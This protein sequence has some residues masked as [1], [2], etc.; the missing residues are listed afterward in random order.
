MAGCRRC[1][2]Q[3]RYSHDQH[4]DPTARHE[5]GGDGRGEGVDGDRSTG[6]GTRDAHEHHKPVGHAQQFIAGIPPCGASYG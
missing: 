4:H 6:A 1:P 5:R 3:R 2:S